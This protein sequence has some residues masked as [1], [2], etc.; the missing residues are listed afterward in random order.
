MMSRTA[1]DARCEGIYP[2]PRPSFPGLSP[3]DSSSWKGGKGEEVQGFLF[4]FLMLLED[5][6]VSPS[7][8]SGSTLRP[9]RSQTSGCVW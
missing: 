1:H 2:H 9:A 4:A 8:R 3:G 5:F 7:N 6:F